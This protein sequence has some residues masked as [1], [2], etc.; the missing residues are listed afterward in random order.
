M[1]L[2]RKICANRGSSMDVT[3]KTT[4]EVERFFQETDNVLLGP[5][6]KM[7]NAQIVFTEKAHTGKCILCC[8]EDVTLTGGKLVFAGPG[9]IVYL[10]S[11]NTSLRLDATV[12]AACTFALGSS[13][14]TNGSL[15]VIV[16][17]RRSVLIGDRG[18]FSFDVWIRTADPHLVYRAEDGRRI[19]PSRDVVIG[20]HVWLG[21][22][23]MLLK[24]AAIGSGSIVGGAAV[25]AGKTVPSN[26]SW[27]GNPARQI[28]R[29]I[30]F[31]GA[32]VHGWT[33]EQTAASQTFTSDK[34][35]YANA[36][37]RDQSGLVRL[38]NRLAGVADAKERIALVQSAYEDK[39][40]NRF[41]IA[42]AATSSASGN[43]GSSFRAFEFLRLRSRRR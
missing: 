3:L 4:E 16:S 12:H 29:G 19:N 14:Y 43:R 7:K 42:E 33:A 23:A 11:G 30:F 40:K 37:Q 13:T 25:V 15:H 27:A 8:G 6:P 21:Q 39:G 28:A 24:G 35:V 1:L 36:P 32:C 9:A 17:E 2:S 18:L 38:A 34:W 26:T 5:P 41:A 10:A 31:D 20:D 22:S